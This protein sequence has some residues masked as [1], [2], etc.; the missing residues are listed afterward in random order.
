MNHHC[1]TCGELGD[2]CD[3]RRCDVC[4][5]PICDR[6]PTALVCGGSCRAKRSRSRRG[7]RYVAK[8]HS[9]PARRPKRAPDMRISYSKAVEA[10]ADAAPQPLRPGRAWAERVL[11][12]LL[13]ERQEQHLR[14][15]THA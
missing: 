5:R 9:T 3:R 10:L 7:V 6:K 8:A 15:D 11:R 4:S 13:T 12:P 1:A 2:E 14:K